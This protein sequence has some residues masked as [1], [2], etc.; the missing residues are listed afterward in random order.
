MWNL[1]KLWMWMKSACVSMNGAAARTLACGTGASASVVASIL[2]GYTDRKVKVHLLGGVLECE[3]CDD[4]SSHDERPC[5]MWQRVNTFI[6][7]FGVS[8]L[9]SNLVKWKGAIMKQA[10]KLEFI[11]IRPIYL[12]ESKGK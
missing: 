1:W 9:V 4:G 7:Y 11:E 10:A 5:L 3:W 2:N 12:R 6:N 8:S